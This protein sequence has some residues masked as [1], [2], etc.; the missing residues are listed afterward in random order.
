MKTSTYGLAVLEAREGRAMNFF[1]LLK[2]VAP[3]GNLVNVQSN[4]Y[5]ANTSNVINSGT[6]NVVGGGSP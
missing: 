4:F 2:T 5:A 6:A 3:S 1:A